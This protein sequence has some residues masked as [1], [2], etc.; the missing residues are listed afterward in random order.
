MGWHDLSIII[1]GWDFKV[2]DIKW[3]YRGYIREYFRNSGGGS[4]SQELTSKKSF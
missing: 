3:N 2:D 1:G 4:M